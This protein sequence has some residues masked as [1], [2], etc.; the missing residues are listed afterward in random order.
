[1]DIDFLEYLWYSYEVIKGVYSNGREGGLRSHIVEVRILS[2]P[3][4]K[5]LSL[6]PTG[7]MVNAVDSKSTSSDSQ[8]KSEVGH[9][10]SYPNFLGC[11]NGKMRASKTFS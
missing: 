3:S 10:I 8:F 4:D 1:M 11:S 9:W 2:R 7:E 6:C 5:K